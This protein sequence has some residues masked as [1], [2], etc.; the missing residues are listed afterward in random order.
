[1]NIEYFDLV[2]VKDKQYYI[3]NCIGKLKDRNNVSIILR[4][5]KDAFKKDKAFK[6]FISLDTL[7]KPLNILTQYNDRWAIEPLFRDCKTYLAL[8]GYQVRT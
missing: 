2:T 6:T 8:D 4:Y 5:P 3:Y 7:L 1:M